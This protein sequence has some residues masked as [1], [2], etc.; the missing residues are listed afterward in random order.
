MLTLMSLTKA[1]GE[2]G[3]K[4]GIN[5]LGWTTLWIVGYCNDNLY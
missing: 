1:P 5:V 3:S 2:S 4:D